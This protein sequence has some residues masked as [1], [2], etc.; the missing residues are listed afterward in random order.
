MSTQYK[1]TAREKKRKCYCRHLFTSA[2]NFFIIFAHIACFVIQH[3]YSNWLLGNTFSLR[4]LITSLYIYIFLVLQNLN[5][6]EDVAVF[7]GCEY[8]IRMIN[9]LFN[10]IVFYSILNLY[11]SNFWKKIVVKKV[12]CQKKASINT[13][14]HTGA[15]SIE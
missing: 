14:A 9:K 7:P 3:K 10:S 1:I 5:F 12:A 4:F 2:V 8:N 11:F 6:N 13:L 15:E